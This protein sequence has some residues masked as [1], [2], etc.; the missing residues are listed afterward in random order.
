MKK[1]SSHWISFLRLCLLGALLC[2]FAVCAHAASGTCSASGDGNKVAWTLS[3]DGTLTISGTGIMKDYERKED[4]STDAPWDAGA[5]KKVVVKKGVTQIGARA[6]SGCRLLSAVSLGQ[7]LKAVCAEAFRDCTALVKITIPN[8]VKKIDVRAFY[9]CTALT[10]A[11]LSDSMTEICEGTFW[12]CSALTSIT[13]PDAVTGIRT[14]A[15]AYCSGLEEIDMGNGVW[16]ADLSAFYTCPLKKLTVGKGIETRK[17]R[18]YQVLLDVDPDYNRLYQIKQLDAVDV[19]EGVTVLPS[20]SFQGLTSVG[21]LSLPDSLTTLGDGFMGD[22][23]LFG[24]SVG[25]AP[26]NVWAALQTQKTYFARVILR[27]GVTRMPEDMLYGCGRL[28]ELTLPK[29]I[30]EIG[31]RALKNCDALTSLTIPE[32]TESIGAEAFN[33]CASLK[34]IN[35]P[36]SVCSVGA[37]AFRGTPWLANRPDGIV[38]A[39][40]VA[41]GYNGELPRDNSLVFRDGTLRIAPQAFANMRWLQAVTLPAALTECGESAFS[42]CE[43]LKEVRIKDLSKWAVTTFVDSTAN[44]LYYAGDLLLNGEAVTDFPTE[45]SGG[46]V[47]AYAFVNCKTLRTVKVGGAAR[48]GASCFL[49]CKK[50][51]RVE[52]DDPTLWC[53]CEFANETANP[54]YQAGALFSKGEI[55]RGAVFSKGLQTVPAYAFIGCKTLREADL[56]AT[57]T[58]VGPYAFNGTGLTRFAPAEGLVTIGKGAFARCADLQSVVLPDSVTQIGENAFSGCSGLLEL[59]LSAD[60]KSVGDDAFNGCE[61]VRYLTMGKLSETWRFPYRMALQSLRLLPG[62]TVV[63]AR[64]WRGCAALTDLTVPATLAEIG[65]GAF[66]SCGALTD[67]YYGGTSAQW[68]A[69]EKRPYNSAVTVYAAIHYSHDT[70][71]PGAPVPS[72]VT[73]PGCDTDGG[74]L[75]TV[76]CTVCGAVLRQ[77]QVTDPSTGHDWGAWTR[78]DDGTHVRICRNDENHRETGAHEWDAGKVT[79]KPACATPGIRTYTCA[80]CG[81]KKTEEIAAP[82]HVWGDWKKLDQTSH[83]RVCQTDATH[84]ETAAHRWDA[85]SVTKAPT[86]E[87]E[88]EKTFTCSVCGATLRETIPALGHDW[89]DWRDTGNGRHTRVCKR[90]ASHVQTVAHRLR[91]GEASPMPTC[92]KAGAWK[93]SCADCGYI[94]TQKLSALGH[95]WDAW[96]PFDGSKHRRVCKNDPAHVQSGKHEWDAGVVI[97]GKRCTDADTRRFTC[98]VCGETKDATLPSAGSHIWDEVVKTSA[99]TCTANGSRTLCCRVCGATQTDQ[100]PA[101]GHDWG[102]WR[103]ANELTHERV[104][105]YNALHAEK[106]P[107]EWGK[108]IMT[109]SSTRTEPFEITYCCAVCGALKT[110]LG[111]TA[112]SDP[113]DAHGASGDVDSDGKTTPADARLTLRASVGLENYKPGSAAFTAADADRNGKIESADARL[114]LR[115]SVGLE[116]LSSAHKWDKGK[117]I[118][119]ADCGM[120]GM[121]V[122]TCAVCGEIRSETVPATGKHEWN[123]GIALGKSTCD[124]AGSVRYVCK[125]C[126]ETKLEV[127]PAA[128][129]SAIACADLPATCETNG[130]KGGTRCTVCGETIKAPAVVKATGHRWNAG[131][132]Q[133]EPTC[134]MQGLRLFVCEVCG[135]GRTEPIDKTDHTPA[136]D[137]Y[138]APTCTETGR[139]GGTHCAVCGKQLTKPETIRSLGGHQWSEGRSVLDATC[140]AQGVEEFV[141]VIC[142]EAR[143]ELTPKAPHTPQGCADKPATCTEDGSTGGTVCAV[144]SAVLTSP[145]V[146]PAVGHVWNEGA[147]TREATC[148][149]TGEK[150][151]RCKVC[152][153]T[154]TEDTPKAPHTPQP[155]ADVAPTCTVDGSTGGTACAVCGAVLEAPT[156]V[157]ATGHKPVPGEGVPAT[158]V[159]D[160]R[161]GGTYCSVCGAQVEAPVVIKATGHRWNGGETVAASTATRSGVKRYTCTVCGAT[162]SERLPVDPSVPVTGDSRSNPANAGDGVLVEL[163]G[164]L[165]VVRLSRIYRGDAAYALVRA[166]NP[167]HNRPPEE[168]GEWRFYVFSLECVS[169]SRGKGHFGMELINYRHLFAPSGARL[170]ISSVSG[171]A[172]PGKRYRASDPN[173]IT[174]YLYDGD[175]TEAAFGVCV[176]KSMGDLLLCEHESEGKLWIRLTCPDVVTDA[177]AV[178]EKTV[179]RLLAEHVSEN[180]VFDSETQQFRLDLKTQYQTVTYLLYEPAKDR[181]TINE[182]EDNARLTTLLLREDQWSTRGVQVYNKTQG[183]VSEQYAFYVDYVSDRSATSAM[184]GK[185]TVTQEP[186]VV[187]PPGSLAGSG[188]SAMG[189]LMKIESEMFSTRIQT[190]MLRAHDLVNSFGARYIEIGYDDLSKAYD[191]SIDYLVAY[192]EETDTYDY[193]QIPGN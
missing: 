176:D 192:D 46:Q 180:G 133:R 66:E 82:G 8:S 153:E 115:A 112:F 116:K 76:T 29:S 97:K 160:G 43:N 41:V 25:N 57:V 169:A 152:G 189:A 186:T 113:A 124:K 114:I 163:D 53:L 74:H 170:N 75:E 84:K 147:I 148:T 11:K 35:V 61:A 155:K 70:H 161:T 100:I 185:V 38:Y 167:Y 90:D 127:I 134:A 130:S 48:F 91:V 118:R 140:T 1:Q 71:T 27:D 55:V 144:C 42:G 39:G 102:A 59:R 33:G 143:R 95:E 156:S 23:R 106:Q 181:L 138:V 149:S 16:K 83:S 13:I 121:C 151:F 105:G 117:T 56:P 19:R 37:N 93:R 187:A 128:G 9:G 81:A 24:V 136:T 94:E 47:S 22:C 158:C 92:T 142:D 126:G 2:A 191:F 183:N 45:L 80:V 135:A 182:Y 31:D 110:E 146:I 175:K 86:C 190:I 188:T 14:T 18:D 5:V 54:L 179:Y 49:G 69:V 132:T 12:N 10:A 98:K 193:T 177:S 159:Q 165:F 88:G 108:G 67:V 119:E 4:G 178:T 172:M 15:F 109:V 44:P 125:V 89:N 99:P 60:L 77:Y 26:E 174:M 78:A 32:G 52:T 64:S 85:V 6:F 30:K 162:R 87:S 123:D 171:L 137:A 28:T 101:H 122:Y 120:P 62:V 79:R 58:A 154:K 139:K 36:D 141:C 164:D 103:A 107:H 51:E 184:Y 7:D 72:D 157:K 50:L 73:L 34:T 96:Q 63:P 21:M 20:L 3:A 173:R 131:E 168:G 17:L 104:C 145:K 129:H 65:E 68:D 40:K 111:K 166:E 150:T